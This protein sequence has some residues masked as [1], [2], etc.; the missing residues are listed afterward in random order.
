MEDWI[1]PAKSQLPALWVQFHGEQGQQLRAGILK[2]RDIWSLLSGTGVKYLGPHVDRAS[3]IPNEGLLTYRPEPRVAEL[4]PAER[5]TGYIQP[6]PAVSPSREIDLETLAKTEWF[7]FEA[8][9]TF[10]S[11]SALLRDPHKGPSSP[12]L[13]ILV[14][15]VEGAMDLSYSLPIVFLQKALEEDQPVSG[16][17]RVADR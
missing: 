13:L 5:T 15:P 7:A 14:T 3:I 2:M 11:L 4:A 6:D 8:G 12:V 17:S 10:P 1:S 16:E 9:A